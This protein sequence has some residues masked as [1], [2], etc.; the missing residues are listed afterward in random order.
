MLLFRSR[1]Q[2]KYEI[3]CKA[4][5]LPQISLQFIKFLLSCI[6]LR[7][8][9]QSHKGGIFKLFNKNSFSDL[10]KSFLFSSSLHIMYSLKKI[11]RNQLFIYFFYL[12]FFCLRNLL[13]DYIYLNYKSGENVISLLEKHSWIQH[14]NVPPN[15]VSTKRKT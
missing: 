13:F 1:I 12:F 3:K 14:S 15:T 10:S 6:L 7:M 8:P 2:S 5:F 4:A 9:E 11:V